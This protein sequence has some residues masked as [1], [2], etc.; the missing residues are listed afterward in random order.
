MVLQVVSFDGF[1]DPALSV[2]NLAV[3]EQFHLCGGWF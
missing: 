3:R 2:K 1:T